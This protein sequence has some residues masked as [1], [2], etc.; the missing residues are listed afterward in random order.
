M[1]FYTG[2]SVNMDCKIVLIHLAKSKLNFH[3]AMY[4]CNSALTELQIGDGKF[5]SRLAPTVELMSRFQRWI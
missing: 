3:R 1:F 2:I 5:N 4:I